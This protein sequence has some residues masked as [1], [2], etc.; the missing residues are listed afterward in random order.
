MAYSNRPTVVGN[1]FLLKTQIVLPESTPELF[2]WDRVLLE[3]LILAHLVK[4]FLAFCETR[5]FL[6]EFARFR[7]W[8]LSG[9][10]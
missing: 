2:P 10:G 1:A 9:A 5:R 7:H 6:T 3:K 8:S 4:E